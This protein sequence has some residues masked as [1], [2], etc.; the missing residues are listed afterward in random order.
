MKRIK[1]LVVA[2]A[3]GAALSISAAA[4]TL[5]P[6]NSN[7]NS[8]ACCDSANC[9]KDGTMSCCKKKR[10]GKN[11]HAC[12]KGKNGAECCCKGDSCPMPSRTAGKTN[13]N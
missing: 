12:C 1:V 11:A 3:C 13:T 8:A 2:L 5:S 10:K 7:Q 4:L 9:C 6:Q